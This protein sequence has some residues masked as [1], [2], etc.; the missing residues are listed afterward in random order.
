MTNNKSLCERAE[1]CA[2]AA[3]RMAVA[4]NPEAAGQR[5]LE[6]QSCVDRMQVARASGYFKRGFFAAEQARESYEQA[7]SYAA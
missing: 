4:G 6:A 1:A 2:R 3:H 5:A 7:V